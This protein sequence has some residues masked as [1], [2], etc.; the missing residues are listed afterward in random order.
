MIHALQKTVA[1][2]IVYL[3]RGADDCFRNLLV[4][5]RC[6]V[7]SCF[8]HSL[9]VKI[10]VHLWQKVSRAAPASLQGVCLGFPSGI[11]MAVERRRHTR[12]SSACADSSDRVRLARGWSRRKTIAVLLR[13][14]RAYR[15][16]GCLETFRRS[17]K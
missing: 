2:L 1:K 8:K 16:N 7:F 5:K 15:A 14:R 4:R 10:C 6:L 9:S 12:R 11:A 13:A 3:E 17:A